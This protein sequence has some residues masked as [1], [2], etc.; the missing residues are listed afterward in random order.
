MKLENIPALHTLN[1]LQW[2]LQL[3]TSDSFISAA[4]TAISLQI[5]QGFIVGYM[6]SEE[7]KTK[8]STW[9]Y[10]NSSEVWYQVFIFQL[11]SCAVQK[12]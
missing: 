7:R 12:P 2:N 6:E 5:S 1:Q 10:F 4:V 11:Q 8:E 3:N 9:N